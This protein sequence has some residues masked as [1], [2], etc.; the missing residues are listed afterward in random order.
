MPT[1]IHRA[2]P[3]DIDQLA[4]LFHHSRVFYV[5]E[6]A[7]RRRGVARAPLQAAAAFGRDAGAL[8]RALKTTPDNFPAQAVYR[9]AGWEPFDGTPWSRLPLSPP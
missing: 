7:H 3:D 6:P 8:R 4:A 1:A 2:G 9:S 5:V